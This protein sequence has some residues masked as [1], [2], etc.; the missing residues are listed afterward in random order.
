MS[1]AEQV[2]EHFQMEAEEEQPDYVL[3]GGLPSG[4]VRGCCQKGCLL[5]FPQELLQRTQLQMG[6]L[7]QNDKNMF[8][9]G[10]MSTSIDLLN[11]ESEL[12]G[13]GE[14]QSRHEVV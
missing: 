1:E 8:I 9:I 2:Q 4:G 5:E 13:R 10:K 14:I 7:S 11:P 3:E 12:T 6:A